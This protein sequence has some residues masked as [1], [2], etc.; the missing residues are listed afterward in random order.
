MKLFDILQLTLSIIAILSALANIFTSYFVLRERIVHV[1]KDI[2]NLQT[3]QSDSKT[4]RLKLWETLEIKENRF[5]K[6]IDDLVAA[7][8]E[9][10][11]AIAKIGFYYSGL[12]L[13]SSSKF[14]ICHLFLPYNLNYY[15]LQK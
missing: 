4:D 2:N 15:L 3:E 7:I 6:R 12:D 13:R 8:N 14:C 1:E 11:V 5:Y 10:R 9:L